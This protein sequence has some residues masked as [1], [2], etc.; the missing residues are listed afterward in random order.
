MPPTREVSR[1]ARKTIY[2]TDYP[3][4][5]GG[6]AVTVYDGTLHATRTRDAEDL[7]QAI[8]PCQACGYDDAETIA[9]ALDAEEADPHA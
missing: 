1:D 6:G 8:T 3:C 9:E 5:C 7:P 4:P 2:A